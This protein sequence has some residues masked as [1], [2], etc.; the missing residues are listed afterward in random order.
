M[1]R[2]ASLGALALV[3]AMAAAT[4]QEMPCAALAGY[5]KSIVARGGRWIELTPE[6]WQF[7][8]GVAAEAPFTPTALPPGDR[9]ALAEAPGDDGGVIL[10]IDGDEACGPLPFP[11]NWVVMLQEVGA[12]EIKH[13]GA[14][15]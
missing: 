3:F 13:V 9:A 15:N 14:D 12:G 8:R 6:Q 4:A 1:F 5:K 7:V 10:F 2:N 11:A